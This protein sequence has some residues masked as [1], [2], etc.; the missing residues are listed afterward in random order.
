MNI[1]V[2]NGHKYE[3]ISFF[4]V[5]PPIVKNDPVEYD[6]QPEPTPLHEPVAVVEEKAAEEGA[7]EGDPEDEGWVFR[8][9]IIDGKTIILLLSIEIELYV[10]SFSC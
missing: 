8:V 5:H 2:G 1:Y 10:F 4:P 3:E 6:I 7:E 9:S